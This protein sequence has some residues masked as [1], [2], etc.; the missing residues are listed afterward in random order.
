LALNGAGTT[1]NLGNGTLYDY[2]FVKYHSFGSV[3]WYVGN[4]SGSVTI[5]GDGGALVWTLFGRGNP[6]VQVPDG[7]ATIMLFGAALAALALARR[8]SALR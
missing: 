4:L 6:R 5:P 1:I 3:V 7:G 8:R 2:L